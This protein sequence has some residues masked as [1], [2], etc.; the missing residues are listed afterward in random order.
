VKAAF[1]V[2]AVAAAVGL[3]A[4][5]FA[6]GTYAAGGSDSSCYALMAE[7]FASGKLQPTSALASQ[8][9]WPDASKTFAPGGFVPSQSDP[10]AS[11]PVCAPGFSLLLAPLVKLG[12][13]NALFAVTPMAGALLVWLTFL[14]GRGL[15]GPLA[16]ATAAVLV[17]ASPVVLYQVVQ[18]MNDATTA[19][20]WMAVFV[21]LVSR[22]WAVAGVCCGLALLVRPNLLPLASV[23]GIF[24]LA[25]PIPNP[26]SPIPTRIRRVALFGV[27][28]LPCVLII[29]WL[30]AA[31]YGGPLRSGYG[32]LGHL[33]SL[34]VFPGNAA[35][36]GRWLIETQT[37][38]P[39]L[40]VFAP[41]LVDREKRPGAFLA[42]GF[43]VTTMVVYCAYQPFDDWSYLRFLLP[44]V[45]LLIV[46][47]GAVITRLGLRLGRRGGVAVVGA[48]AIGL[49]VFGVRR[50][51]ERLAFRLQALEQRYRS[52]GIVVRDR[53][54]S[55]AVLLTVW[56][57]GAVRFH[58]RKEAVI[59]EG[60]D[61]AWLDHGLDWLAAHGH[62][63]YILVESWEEPGFRARFAGR[64]PIGNLDWPPKYEVD[65]VVR[66]YDPVDRARYLRG[67]RV[68][69]EY[70]WPLRKPYTDGWLFFNP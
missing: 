26:R 36:Y 54:P 35:R 60:L 8:V 52:A 30:N 68:T 13:Q 63:P 14:A 21:A 7:A 44:A 67:E 50:A 31:L 65:R 58:G 28:A 33:F 17:A 4:V 23:A 46:L 11:A 37:P 42:L 56:D 34:S 55:D 6:R 19:A 41:F 51:D 57:S 12:G 69:T 47:A 66:I 61:P 2:I 40:A 38:F 53:L 29:L 15:A 64:S 59:W 45:T 9:P 20:L 39:L 70:L 49:A 22:R 62:A 1:L 32:Q 18:P 16:G 25:A 10:T 27:A 48:V 5:G 3:A 43:I 24:V